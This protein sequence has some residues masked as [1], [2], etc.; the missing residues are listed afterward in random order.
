M[1]WWIL[2]LTRL[3][4]LACHSSLLKLWSLHLVINLWILWACLHHNFQL[5]RMTKHPK[6]NQLKSWTQ[7]VSKTQTSSKRRSNNKSCR[8][9]SITT[10][11]WSTTSTLCSVSSNAPPKASKRS[12]P[13]YPASSTTTRNSTKTVP[14]RLKRRESGG[15]SSLMIDSWRFWSSRRSWKLSNRRKEGPWKSRLWIG[16]PGSRTWFA[17]DLTRRSL[18]KRSIW[19]GSIQRLIRERSYQNHQTKISLVKDLHNKTY[20][21]KAEE[22][23]KKISIS[24]RMCPPLCSL[25]TIL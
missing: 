4:S 20:I 2:I 10:K 17:G 7:S 13:S 18:I 24:N 1:I 9:C 21:P 6:Q 19:Y 3:N 22:L 12:S 15:M 5:K 16:L 25:D 8:N 11:N 14:R 23:P